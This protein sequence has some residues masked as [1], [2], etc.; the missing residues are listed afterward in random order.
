M[1]ARV[2]KRAFFIIYF[3]LLQACMGV[4]IGC[5][6]LALAM[7]AGGIFTRSACYFLPGVIPVVVVEEEEEEFLL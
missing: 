1:K 2:R 4:R 6:T 5:Q 7:A 3:C